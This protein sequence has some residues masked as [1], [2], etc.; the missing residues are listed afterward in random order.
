MSSAFSLKNPDPT[1]A[2]TISVQS[3]RIQKVWNRNVVLL[4]FMDKRPVS[5]LWDIDSTTYQS[6]CIISDDEWRLVVSAGQYLSYSPE[7]THKWPLLVM[8]ISLFNTIDPDKYCSW[9]EC[10]WKKWTTS[11]ITILLMLT[12]YN[13]HC[14]DLQ[15]DISTEPQSRNAMR[16]LCR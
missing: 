9:H 11:L 7:Q 2:D 1:W 4:H 6:I 16:S 15:S 14:G 8:Q 10:S 12:N 13:S 5:V 3:C